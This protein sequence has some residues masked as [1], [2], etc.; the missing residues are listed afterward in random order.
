LWPDTGRAWPV[1]SPNLRTFE[2]TVAYAGVVLLETTTVSEGRGTESPFQL[3]GAPGLDGAPLAALSVPGFSLTPARFTPRQSSAAAPKHSGTACLGVRIEVTQPRN[4]HPYQLGV[5]LLKALRA[6][7]ALS[8]NSPAALDE[9]LGTPRVRAAIERGDS[10]AAMVA[11]DAAALEA[12]QKE[13]AR[14]LLY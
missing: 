1:P 8:W 5:S 7:G 6:Q 2:G 14:A 4:A 11:A 13:R 12:F 9:F 3:I 10:V